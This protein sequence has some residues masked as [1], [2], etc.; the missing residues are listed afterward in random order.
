MNNTTD[1]YFLIF[2]EKIFDNYEIMDKIN[3][4]II[5][6]KYVKCKI[7]SKDIGGSYIVFIN[8]EDKNNFIQICGK[9]KDYFNIMTILEYK[10]GLKNKNK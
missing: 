4:E 5:N 2:N 7:N 3:E 1:A 6:S 8:S 9:Y 10:E